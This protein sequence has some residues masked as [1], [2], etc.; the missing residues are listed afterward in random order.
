MRDAVTS[1]IQNYDVTGRYLDR[2]AVDSLKSYF[3][4][5]TA[6]V[7]AATVIN[8]NAAKLVKQAGLTLFAEQPEL[9]RPGGNAYTT[10]RYAACLR[11]MDYYLRYATYALVAADTDV[12]DERVLQGLRETYNSL[13]VPIGPTVIG[14][15]IMKDLVK[16]EVQAAGLET[17]PYLDEPFDYMISELGEK[18]I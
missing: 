4:T 5:G 7:Q 8:A 15:G 6:R 9:I 17:G 14:I 16:A 11:D 1:L 13:G 2:D 12:L 10:R 18:D 3:A